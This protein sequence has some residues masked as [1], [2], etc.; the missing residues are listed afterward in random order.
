MESALLLYAPYC[1]GSLR[2]PE[3]EEALAL[4]ASG[5]LQ[6]ARRLRP[7][8]SRPF[9]M[10]WQPVESPLAFTAVSLVFEPPPGAAAAGP[11]LQYSFSVPSHRLVLWLMDRRSSPDPP[12]PLVDLPESFWSWLILGDRAAAVAA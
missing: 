8:G 2:R 6:G 11:L 5:G 10:H 1:Q 9:R 4:L 12:Q 7:S 3:L